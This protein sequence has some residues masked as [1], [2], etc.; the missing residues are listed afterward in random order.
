MSSEAWGRSRYSK[1]AAAGKRCQDVVVFAADVSSAFGTTMRAL[2]LAVSRGAVRGKPV[3]MAP[4]W[5]FLLHPGCPEGGLSCYFE[6]PL[7]CSPD[8]ET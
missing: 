3:A 2:A 8:S 5:H 4:G 1:G 7:E 6:H